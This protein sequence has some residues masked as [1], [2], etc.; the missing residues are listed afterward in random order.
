MW[1]STRFSGSVIRAAVQG[2]AKGRRTSPAQN[3]DRPSL[4]PRQ[5][6]PEGLQ[7]LDGL[8]DP[9]NEQLGE[10]GRIAGDKCTDLLHVR[11]RLL[12]PLD[13]HPRLRRRLAS[14]C[15]TTWPARC[16]APFR[17]RGTD[18]AGTGSGGA[19]GTRALQGS[20]RVGWRHGGAGHAARPG[21]IAG[22]GA[23]ATEVAA[24]NA[25]SPRTATSAAVALHTAYWPQDPMRN[26]P[27]HAPPAAGVGSG[28]AVAAAAAC[29]RAA[30]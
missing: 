27:L 15:E 1:V 30:H 25:R 4:A 26:E 29:S 13:A 23:P 22:R 14:A 18:V 6:D 20:D 21:T 28:P 19:A 11:E 9:I 3:Q 5:A 2:T 17:S 8:E 16:C 7:P 10:G 12:G 24:T